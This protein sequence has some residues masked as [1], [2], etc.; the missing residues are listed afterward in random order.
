MEIT[1]TGRHTSVP[2]RFQRHIEEKLAKVN[3]LDPRV[4][5]CEV[6]V[7]HEPN[8]RQA[9]EA[10]RVEITCYGKRAVIRAEASADDTYAAL[11]LAATRLGE[12]LRRQHDKRRVH[13][14][15]RKAPKSVHDATAP[16]ADL[17]LSNAPGDEEQEPPI[18]DSI[19]RIGGD[20]D[21]PVEL[22]EKTHRTSPMTVDQAIG[23]MEAVGHDFFFFHDVDADRP[24]VVYRRRGWSYGMITLDVEEKAEESA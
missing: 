12:R 14:G 13:R 1:V 3:Q 18:P 20:V 4:T 15:G 9:K 19:A 23:H 11:D 22:R 8:P 21:C 5:R 7:S 16:L 2:E 6:I 17:D 24:T 10:E